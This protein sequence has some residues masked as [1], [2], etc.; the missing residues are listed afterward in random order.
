MV[1]VL[2]RDERAVRTK[3]V[4]HANCKVNHAV[5][6]AVDKANQFIHLCSN[7]CCLSFIINDDAV[8]A[9]LAIV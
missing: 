1:N 8:F 4:A 6:T 2:V 7:A 5:R 3:T 9:I